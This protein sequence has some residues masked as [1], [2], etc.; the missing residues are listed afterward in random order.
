[1]KPF[2]KET[3]SLKEI[4]AATNLCFAQSSGT[5]L[6]YVFR[7]FYLNDSE[8]NHCAKGAHPAS[9]LGILSKDFL[10]WEGNKAKTVEQRR[11]A[12]DHDRKVPAPLWPGLVGSPNKG[13]SSYRARI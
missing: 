3:I 12:A 6:D 8:T 1:M 13:A 10:L 9:S 11:T 2:R 7:L 4:R 5:R